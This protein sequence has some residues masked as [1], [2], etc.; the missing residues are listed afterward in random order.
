M[1]PVVLISDVGEGDM[2]RVG[3]KGASLGTLTETGLDV[4]PGFIVTAGAFRKF[5]QDTG[6][7]DEIFSLLEE[8]ESDD[9]GSLKNVS[10]EIEGL[11]LGAEFPPYLREEIMKFYEEL[12]GDPYVAVRSSATAE[13]L[14]EASFAGQQET[15]LNVKGYDDLEE[16]IRMCWASLYTPRAIFYRENQDFEHEKVDIAVVVQRMVDAEKAGVMFTSHP[17][18][19]KREALVEAAWG[20]G[21]SVVSGSVSPDSYTVDRE[22]ENVLDVNVARKEKMVVRRDG[23]TVTEKVPEEKAEKRVLTEEELDDLVDLADRL[24]EYYG[25]PQDVEWAI[26]EDRVYILQSRPIT[27]IES[28]KREA[29]EETGEVMVSGL[30]ASPGRISGPVKAIRSVDE[31]DRVERGDILVTSMT[32][33]DMVPAMKRAAGI[34][35]DEGGLTSHA[36]IVSRELGTPCVVG[37][38]KSTVTLSDGQIVTLDG[39]RG[40]VYAGD[41]VS[42]EEVEGEGAAEVRV[43]EYPEAT[44]TDVKVNISIPGAAE[45]AAATGADGVGLLRLEHVVLGLDRHPSLYIGEGRGDEYVDELFDGVSRVAE[46]FYPKRVWIRTLDAPTDEFRSMKGGEDEP[47]EHNP[48]LGYRGIRRDLEEKEHFSLEA[49]CFK[50]LLERG[51]DNIG[52]MLP[53]I[54]EVGQVREAR[55]VLESE[56]VDLER[57]DFGVMI[58]TPASALIIEELAEEGVDFVSFGTNDLTQYTLGVDRNNE[59][60][61]KLY[62]SDHPAVIRLVERVIEKCRD[63]GVETSICGQAGSDPD[64]VDT[65]VRLGIDSISANIDAVG[66]VRRRVSVIEKRILLESARERGGPRRS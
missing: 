38:K 46:A 30:P 24:E 23:S 6:I 21:E 43:A 18:T 34:V 26:V 37:T 56:G 28:K 55:E 36:A 25:S 53:L 50:K 17:T 8:V 51:L 1:K 35:T 52:I 22:S 58:E 31:L 42:E 49:R 15:Y 16:A 41:L 10:E 2:E 7:A 3:G 14:P 11:I 61:E 39:E 12:D 57:V 32:T 63:L 45:R 19:G 48:M 64:Y 60:V 54:S 27:T 5:I 9:S 20:L 65:L 44:A 66:E 59:N 47:V 4:P 62:R 33:P 29:E 40:K 13:D